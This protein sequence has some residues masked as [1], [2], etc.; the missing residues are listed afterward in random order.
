MRER[1]MMR[2]RERGREGEALFPQ[3]HPV[4]LQREIMREIMRER[5]IMR[6][7]ESEITS[8]RVWERPLPRRPILFLSGRADEIVPPHM[9]TAL[10]RAA[11]QSAGR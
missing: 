2:E 6:D 4:P 8:E 5:E 1:E 3:A 9:M 10:Y 11:T 7:R